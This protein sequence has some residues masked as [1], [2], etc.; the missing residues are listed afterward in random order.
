MTLSTLNAK[1]LSELKIF[2]KERQ[3]S[4]LNEGLMRLVL[5]K[6]KLETHSH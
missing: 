1:D 5:K 4:F 6:M 3:K 2:E